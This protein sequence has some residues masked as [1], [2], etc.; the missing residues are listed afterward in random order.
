MQVVDVIV[1]D[2][3][4][5]AALPDLLKQKN[6][7][8]QP[9][10]TGR[11]GTKRHRTHR[12]QPCAS[13]RIAAGKK[14]DYMSLPNQFFCEP[15][16]HPFGS[17]VPAGWN[18]FIQKRGHLGDSHVIIPE[19]MLDLTLRSAGKSKAEND[20][21]CRHA[22]DYHCQAALRAVPSVVWH[23]HLMQFCAI[24]CCHETGGQL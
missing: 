13:K 2:V 7:M 15:G 9:L 14:R 17:S 20:R 21:N 1:N 19:N 24:E 16:N 23:I 8:G 5:G 4:F 6:M 22:A 12:H 10:M 11:V 3:E 18:G